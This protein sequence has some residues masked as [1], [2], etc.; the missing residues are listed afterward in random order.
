MSPASRELYR[1][2][3]LI[4]LNH[5]AP[6]A[7]PTATLRV[8]AVSSGHRVDEEEC[9]RELAY[10]QDKGLARESTKL[11]SPENKRW[12]ITAAGRDQLATEGLA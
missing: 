11:I 9:L 4:Q 12:E 3:L 6:Y 8:M 1:Q 2:C 7:V 5:A 10:L